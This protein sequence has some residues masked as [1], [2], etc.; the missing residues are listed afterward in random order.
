MDALGGCT[1]QVNHGLATAMS[2][3]KGQ[4]QAAVFQHMTL[5]SVLSPDQKLGME[6]RAEGE[7]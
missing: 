2:L 1:R 3:A 6:G 5:A 7:K 4:P